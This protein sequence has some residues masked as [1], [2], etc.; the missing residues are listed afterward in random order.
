[1]RIWKVEAVP[2][3]VDVDHRLHGAVDEC[4]NPGREIPTRRTHEACRSTV[5]LE[6]GQYPHTLSLRRQ[7][8]PLS[9]GQLPQAPQSREHHVNICVI[10]RRDTSVLKDGL[11]ASRY[12]EHATLLQRIALNPSLAMPAA[13]STHA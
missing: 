9:E 8:L 7:V 12:D 4:T 6:F 2:S 10:S 11:T 1:M 13:P 5:L 3:G